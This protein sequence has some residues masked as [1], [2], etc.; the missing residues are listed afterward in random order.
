MVIFESDLSISVIVSGGLTILLMGWDRVII[1]IKI[2]KKKQMLQLGL[3]FQWKN[4]F[5]IDFL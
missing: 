1:L 4:A 2:I 3:G 5:K